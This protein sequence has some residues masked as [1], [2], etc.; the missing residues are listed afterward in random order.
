MTSFM[1]KQENSDSRILVLIPAY[2][3]GERLLLLIDGLRERTDCWGMTQAV[4]IISKRYG[5]WDTGF[6]SDYGRLD[7][8]FIIISNAIPKRLC[9]PLVFCKI[10]FT[11]GFRMLYSVRTV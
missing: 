11:A 1:W 4:P 7:C 3:P 5:A 9:V 2:E 10:R 8:L 6:G